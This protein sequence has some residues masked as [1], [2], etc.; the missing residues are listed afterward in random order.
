M[1][2]SS[3]RWHWLKDNS[4]AWLNLWN[5]I[6]DSAHPFSSSQR[7]DLYPGLMALP[8]IQVPPFSF[9]ISQSP[10]PPVPSWCL[11]DRRLT[12]T[13]SKK[14]FW[15]TSHPAGQDNTNLN[16]SGTQILSPSRWDPV[17]EDFS[18]V[19]LVECPH[20]GE[21]L[22]CD[23]PGIRNR[24][25]DASKGREV[26]WVLKSCFDIG[27][28]EHERIKA[29][30]KLLMAECKSQKASGSLQRGLHLP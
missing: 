5:E 13:I 26:N 15:L 22:S 8:P 9:H 24:G 27:K 30:K 28:R 16:G 10:G 25:H 6:W 29:V 17:V 2:D 7:S 1:E 11:S 23:D 19:V 12:L 3:E 20:G 14:G 21:Y 4:L 18:I